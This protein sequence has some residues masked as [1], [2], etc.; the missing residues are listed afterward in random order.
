MLIAHEGRA[1]AALPGAVPGAPAAI[2]LP[3]VRHEQPVEP[4]ATEGGPLLP[5]E[6]IAP[7]FIERATADSEEASM[8]P[9][10]GVLPAKPGWMGTAKGLLRG[11][12]FGT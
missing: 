10:G 8:L 9:P 7:E 12:G 11:L 2:A 1:P 5:R 6:R 3:A 4:R